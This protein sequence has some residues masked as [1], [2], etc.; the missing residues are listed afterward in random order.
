MIIAKICMTNLIALPAEVVVKLPVQNVTELE[1][2]K[3]MIKNIKK[4]HFQ[5]IEMG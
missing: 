3:M 1:K 4:H 2:L 5:I